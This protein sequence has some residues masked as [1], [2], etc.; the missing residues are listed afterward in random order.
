M[1]NRI[2]SLTQWPADRAERIDKAQTDLA[3]VI[4]IE[5]IVGAEVN[6]IAVNAIIESALDCLLEEGRKAA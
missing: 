1:R 5:R 3:F 4:A 6:T 2:R